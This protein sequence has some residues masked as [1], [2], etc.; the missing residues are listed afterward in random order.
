MHTVEARPETAKLSSWAVAALV[1]SIV[2]LGFAASPLVF[3]VGPSILALFL[4]SYAKIEIKKSLG[5]KRG[6]GVAQAASWLG[7]LGVM[8]RLFIGL[9]IE[10]DLGLLFGGIVGVGVLVIAIHRFQRKSE[11]I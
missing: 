7:A 2:G 5:A 9:V 1:I 10:D 3:P 4:A 11:E 6:L 8:V